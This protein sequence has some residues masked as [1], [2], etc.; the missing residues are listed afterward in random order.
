[1]LPYFSIN[2]VYLQRRRGRGGAIFILGANGLFPLDFSLSENCVFVRK[3]LPK[4][5]KFGAEIVSIF[6]DFRGKMKL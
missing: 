6:G 3:H 2:R 1:V 4:N 5:T